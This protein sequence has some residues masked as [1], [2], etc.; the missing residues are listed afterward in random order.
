VDGSALLAIL[1]RLVC[2]EKLMAV[3]QSIAVRVSV[4]I[5]LHQEL[6]STAIAQL[7]SLTMGSLALILMV[8]RAIFV[9]LMELVSILWLLEPVPLAIAP[10]VFLMMKESA[11]TSTVARIIWT[12]ARLEV[13]VAV[14]V[15]ILLLLALA[16]YVIARKDIPRRAPHV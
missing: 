14:R 9:G 8:V 11:M 6:G 7:V 2:A 16:T 15:L 1:I 4:M 3:L 5:P 12:A 10:L 13:I